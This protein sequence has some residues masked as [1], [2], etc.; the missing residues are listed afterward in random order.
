MNTMDWRQN[1][2]K[3]F[4]N[5]LS[6][7]SLSP[8]TRRCYSSQIRQF[9]N[10]LTVPD[11]LTNAATLYDAVTRYRCWLSDELGL[12]SVSVNKSLLAIEHLYRFLDFQVPKLA[13]E[14]DTEKFGPRSLDRDE[15]ERLLSV[16]ATESARD[17]AILLLFLTGGI[18]IGECAAINFSEL[19]LFT[20]TPNM[21]IRN[22]SA[23]TQA[24][25]CL[26]LTPVVVSVL[27]DW[28]EER[29]SVAGIEAE[30]LFL[31]R[32]G[33]RLTVS[34]IDFVVRKIGI[35]ANLNI[36]AEV[37]R[38][39]CFNNLLASS[40]DYA[41]ITSI[42]SINSRGRMARSR[43]GLQA[44]FTRNQTEQLIEFPNLTG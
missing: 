32:Q 35:K 24:A 44:D 4:Q 36:S 22:Q 3:A 28:H 13:R 34:A 8:N 16:T 7:Q 15:E 41:L 23:Q 30:A 25:R 1:F 5:S 29:R 19:F 12:R 39:T 14:K 31:S 6:T 26:P 42:V 21:T 2:L 43:T 17:R 11:E 38:Q 27:E 10:F 40:N 20:E 9:L 18:R 33:T 37:L